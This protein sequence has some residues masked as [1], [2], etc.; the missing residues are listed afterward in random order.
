MLQ[1]QLKKAFHYFSVG[2][3]EIATGLYLT[4]VGYNIAPPQK[5][6]PGAGHPLDFD[7]KWAKGRILT[8]TA[9]VYI[10]RGRGVFEKRYFNSTWSAGEAVILPPGLWHRYCPDK[11]TGWTE[12][13][14]TLS[15]ELMGRFWQQNSSHLAT[16]PS[17]VSARADFLRNFKSFHQRAMAQ[18]SQRSNRQS[19]ELL[20][21][22]LQL[23]GHVADLQIST[24]TVLPLENIAEKAR[25]FIWSNSHRSLAPRQIAQAVGVSR[26]TLERHFPKSAGRTVREELEWHRALRAL[27]LLRETHRPIKEIAYL[28][29]FREHRG[30]IRAFKRWHNKLPS[31][32][33][34]NNDWPAKSSAIGRSLPP[35]RKKSSAS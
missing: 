25:H 3:R 17:P 31:E 21:L 11:E 19:L 20:G 13:W 22:G 8:D 32:L 6:Y 35:P 4:S 24:P 28:S 16:E 5:S 7:F 34:F 14:L 15:G 29:G 26:R 27:K 18:A 9:L 10:A 33:R 2:E 1:I 30:M 23:F 12:L